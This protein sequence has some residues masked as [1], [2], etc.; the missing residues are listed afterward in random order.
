MRRLR[1]AVPVD[2]GQEVAL[3]AAVEELLVE[4]VTDGFTLYCC[5]SKDAPYALVASY[6]WVHYVDLLTVGDFE[7][8]VTARV[9]TLGL[10]VDIFA[11]P[12]C[13]VGL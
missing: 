13:G 3:P 5:G 10:P 8:I 12:G 7:R 1:S 2:G 4:M 9:P 11:T 6:E